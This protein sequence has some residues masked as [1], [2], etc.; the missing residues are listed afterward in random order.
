MLGAT[1]NRFASRVLDMHPPDWLHTHLAGC[2]PTW[3]VA[4]PPGWLRPTAHL[5]AFHSCS[6]PPN[7]HIRS[8]VS[9]ELTDNVQ[10][11]P[12]EEVLREIST[13]DT[14]LTYVAAQRDDMPA[15][16]EAH[17]ELHAL[18]TKASE[19]LRESM[20]QKIHAVRKPMYVGRLRE[21]HSVAHAAHLITTAA[22]AAA[23]STRSTIR[24]TTQ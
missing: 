9:A 12:V 23:T 4:Y 21:L 10:H 17:R 13:I 22:A 8:G 3:L 16:A 24:C 15:T 11:A 14:K 5:P 7:I 20:L 18:A 2:I 19:R 1:C 6:P